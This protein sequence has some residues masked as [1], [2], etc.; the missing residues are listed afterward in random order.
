MSG[1]DEKPYKV[2]KR[3]SARACEVCHDRKV[4]CDA[5]V[6]MPCSSCQAF[7]LVCRLREKKGKRGRPARSAGV[8]GAAA[9]SS[10]AATA[11]MPAAAAAVRDVA[12]AA[13][14]ANP[15]NSSDRAPLAPPLQGSGAAS[16]R[17][18]GIHGA[19]PGPAGVTAAGI[20]VT[21]SQTGASAG[22]AA[23]ANAS[24]SSS[25]RASASANAGAG[26][27]AAT[28][29]AAA[30]DDQAVRETVSNG[31][32]FGDEYLRS[33]GLEPGVYYEAARQDRERV[34]VYFG[35][36]S[37]LSL[38]AG[39]PFGEGCNFASAE[40]LRASL[41]Q[42]GFGTPA[43]AN[44]EL[45]RIAGAFLLPAKE[46]CDE[47]VQL[48]FHH[49]HP[50]MPLMDRTEFMRDYRQHSCSIFLLQAMLCVAVKLS[51]NPRLTG[52]DGSTDLASNIFYQRAKAL[53]DSRYEEN[54]IC[55]LQG[56][57]LLS[58]QSFNEKNTIHMPMYFIKN[59]IIVAQTYGLHRSA[60]FHP[61]L[62]NN[63]KK[64]RK[65]IWWILY[66]IDAF[67]SVAIG[68]PQAINLDDCDV[69]VLTH[70]DFNFDGQR[71]EHRPPPDYM[72]CIICTV[73]IAEIMSRISKELSRPSNRQCDA[74]TLIQ[75]FDFLLQRWRLNLPQSLAYNSNAEIFTKHS[76]PKAFVNALYY[77]TL[78]L[79][80][81]SNI[82]DVICTS[83]D[84][85][86]SAGIAF[87]A[88]HSL[89]LIGQILLDRN[90]LSYFYVSH[91]YCFFEALIIFVHHMY[92][93]KSLF[94]DIALKCFHVLE[95]VLQRFG[96]QW[97]SC[98]LLSK[99]IFMFSQ[100]P[101]YI[102][103]VVHR[104]KQNLKT[105][106]DPNI[107]I[108]VPDSKR[109]SFSSPSLP[110]GPREWSMPKLNP[111]FQG[112]TKQSTT[113]M[114]PNS[115][116]VVAGQ[117]EMYPAQIQLG[118]QNIDATARS[119]P[120]PTQLQF[121]P[122]G[123]IISSLQRPPHQHHTPPQPRPTSVHYALP[124]LNF[125]TTT[126]TSDA[127]R[128]TEFDPHQLFPDVSEPLPP[129]FQ[130][131]SSQSFVP[132]D[133]A[134][135]RGDDVEQTGV[136][137]EQKSHPNSDSTAEETHHHTDPRTD[138]WEQQKKTATAAP[139]TSIPLP[140][141]FWDSVKV[142]LNFFSPSDTFPW[143]AEPHNH[144]AD[145]EYSHNENEKSG[146]PQNS[147]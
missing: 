2:R 52:S 56:M 73:Q 115:Q 99:L 96:T 124:E 97:N 18:A 92:D 46:I 36:S 41:P 91:A 111:Q 126:I 39:S 6:R 82:H 122:A 20:N 127:H 104:F 23:S 55:L 43:V 22:A 8:G 123:P 113:P 9:A 54:E 86:N 79:L 100:K 147:S 130:F 21:L 4:R 60:E 78:C 12:S 108:E 114:Y 30:H 145:E 50:L 89:S 128:E 140:P 71:P 131:V 109:E 69:P 88:A 14:C 98:A 120:I 57:I 5:N 13:A 44:M 101:D 77:K 11:P 110:P 75:H 27:A 29:A 48:Y 83:P 72:D 142:N 112:D 80:H 17:A 133:D 68:R 51:P 42:S 47:L 137:L 95:R 136:K 132:A 38:L 31:M 59:A 35:S 94:A 40:K 85:Y 65:L 134:F 67:A 32:S 102:R 87:Q 135:Y 63:E 121:V 139:K 19:R 107:P 61:T 103:E 7:G 15:N 33:H 105:R 3:R 146:W 144:N 16:S 45:L 84:G 1:T 28:A 125:T 76:I 143:P 117:T 70:D 66:V 64:A 81:K 34:Y 119:A 129:D 37:F 118:A 141:G 26:T 25:A 62:T 10:S 90:E 53:Y 93:P 106:T 49:I 58:K 74:T 116:Y 138:E 24:A